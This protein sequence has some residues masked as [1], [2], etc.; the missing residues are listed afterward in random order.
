[1][2]GSER[3]TNSQGALFDRDDLGSLE[4]VVSALANAATVSFTGCD[5][6]TACDAVLQ[7]ERARRFLDA[8]ESHALAELEAQ[9]VTDRAFGLR[10]GPWLAERA[11]L[12]SGVAKARVKTAKSLATVLPD[13]DKALT[14]GDIGFDH[15]KAFADATNPRNADQM[16]GVSGE[17]CD[18]AESMM[19]LAWRRQLDQMAELFDED[20]AYDPDAELARNRLR[21]SPT[22]D[23]L[24]LKGELV[25]EN[26]LITKQALNAIADEL[27]DKYAKDREACP[28]LE[29]PN[30]PTLLAQALVEACRRGLA[31]PLDSTRPGRP[32]ASIILTPN[33]NYPTSPGG[34]WVA[35]SG[36]GQRPFR[37][38]SEHGCCADEP[39][40][41]C[42]HGG[43]GATAGHGCSHGEFGA[44]AGLPWN[45]MFHHGRQWAPLR[46]FAGMS[47]YDESGQPLNQRA[48]RTL[49]CDPDMYT[50]IVN[51]L[52]VP[53]DMGRKI[54][55]ANRVQRRAL[56]LRDGGC[57]FPGCS[58]PASWTETHHSKH[59]E[60]GGK[61][62]VG[63]LASLCRHHHGVAHR[64]GWNVT[65]EADGWTNWTTP[66][67]RQFPGQQHQQQKRPPPPT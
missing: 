17:L 26:S 25:G 14:K 28:E 13:V 15:A 43:F 41:G 20:G 50:T 53:L 11:S 52:G 4:A 35:D 61:T 49:L 54:R 60:H 24:I 34:S 5:E 18:E 64:R 51:S 9:S 3:N 12:P 1:M 32:E 44:T 38:D 48:W 36:V 59:W 16:S 45:R 58:A 40:H 2:F 8:T 27:F 67:G 42:S 33:P 57:T 6:N 56:A 47:V 10:T 62:D 55:F 66:E 22:G 39:G 31:T 46:D 63:D 65:V 23:T 37:A 30:R 29:I 7:L 19:F 21:L